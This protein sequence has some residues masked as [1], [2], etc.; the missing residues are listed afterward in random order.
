MTE[1]FSDAGLDVSRFQSVSIL[2]RFV[3]AAN[4]RIRCKSGKDTQWA[5]LATARSDLI[6]LFLT[7]ARAGSE[8]RKHRRDT[9]KKSYTAVA[10]LKTLGCSLSACVYI[11]WVIFTQLPDAAVAE[12]QP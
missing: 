1:K 6:I 9:I 2:P 12:F 5:G 8:K 11:Q 3:A 10:R 7:L 4:S